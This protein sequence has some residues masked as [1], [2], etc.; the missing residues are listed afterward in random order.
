MILSI[1]SGIPTN[2]DACGTIFNKFKSILLADP[3][4][5]DDT[6]YNIAT[7]RNFA[8]ND[9]PIDIAFLDIFN[10]ETAYTILN[11]VFT[12]ELKKFAQDFDGI[13]L[14]GNTPFS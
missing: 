11:D 13:Y 9:T 6:K 5:V 3:S 4:I 10:N 8:T 14:R 12:S 2:K 1:Q 7:Y